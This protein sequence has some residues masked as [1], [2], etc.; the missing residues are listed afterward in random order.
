VRLIPLGTSATIW[1]TVPAPDDR[2][3]WVW[4]SRWNENWQGKLK[5]SEKTCLN[6][7]LSIIHPTWPDLGLNQGRRDGKPA[8]NYLRYDTARCSHNSSHSYVFQTCKQLLLSSYRVYKMN[9]PRRD[10]TCLSLWFVSETS[11]VIQIRFVSGIH[12]KNYQGNLLVNSGQLPTHTW[13]QIEH[14]LITI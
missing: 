7:T 12:I 11:P 2:W 1:P 8:N 6:A 10:H 14:C 3:W 4:S 9:A 13:N 5:Y